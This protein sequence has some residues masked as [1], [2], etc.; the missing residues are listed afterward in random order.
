VH[1]RTE[2]DQPILNLSVD[3]SERRGEWTSLVPDHGKIMHLFLIR[4]TPPGAFAHLHPVARN[5]TTFDVPLPPVPA[6]LY[7]VYADVTHENGFTETLTATM[8]IASPSAAQQK[9]WLGN[10]IEPVC[11]AEVARMLAT[12]LF[13]PPDIDDSWQMDST[14]TTPPHQREA[15]PAAVQVSGGYKMIWNNPGSL[16]AN[17]DVSLRFTLNTPDNQPALIEPYMGM[18]GHAVIRRQNGAVFAHVH[19]VGTFSMAAQQFFLKASDAHPGPLP[20]EPPAADPPL[21]D[22]HSNLQGSPGE[23]SFPY[24]FPQPGSYRIWVQLKSQGRILTAVFD[25]TVQAAK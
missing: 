5:S 19:P 12:N 15:G 16:V 8:E 3:P 20:Q 4:D 22:A 2:H 17:H 9:L 25:T 6:G 13:Y 23:V 10:S 18:R 11:S 1:V 14:T 21:H 7:H 24:V